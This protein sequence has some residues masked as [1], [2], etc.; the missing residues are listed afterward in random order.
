MDSHIINPKIVD[1]LEVHRKTVSPLQKEMEEFAQENKIPILDWKSIELLELIVEIKQ[2]K[3]ILEIGT[4]IAY[5]SIKIASKMH[6]N[7]TLDTIEKSKN[8][9]P[10]AQNFIDKA[11]LTDKINIIFGSAE[12]V[13]AHSTKIYDL[14]FLDADKIYYEQLMNLSVDR[15]EMG[16]I[17]FV[18]NLLWKGYVA[19]ENIPNNLINST[20]IVKDF[21]IKFLNHPQLDA[22]IYPIGDGIGIAVKK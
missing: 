10:L 9:L 8:N 18:D 14:I 11:G 1:Y 6:Q 3:T 13:L 22:K 19:E 15:L 4:A 12:D 7:A 2:P 5:S 21:N 20:N 16:G 17:L